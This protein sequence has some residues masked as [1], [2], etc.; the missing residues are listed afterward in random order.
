MCIMFIRKSREHLRKKY[1]S[2]AKA[3]VSVSYV[4]FMKNE[5]LVL[6]LWP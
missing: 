3:F 6:Y 1:S 4:P 5:V 2:Y